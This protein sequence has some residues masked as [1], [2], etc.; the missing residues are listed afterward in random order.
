MTRRNTSFHDEFGIIPSFLKPLAIVGF[1][2][3]MFIFLYVMPRHDPH[4]PPFPVRL[5]MSVVLGS[6]LAAYLLLVGYVNQDAK[7]RNMGQLLWTLLV[8]FIPNGIG[9]LAYFLLRKPL[10][11]SCPKCGAL[12]EQGFHF[13]PKCGYSLTPTCSQCGKTVSSD[14]VVCP[15]CGKTLGPATL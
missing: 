8:I 1:V 4:A 10:V 14:Y 9:F 5:F 2:C 12:G 11:Q 7:R 3:M 13:C 6:V 15:Y